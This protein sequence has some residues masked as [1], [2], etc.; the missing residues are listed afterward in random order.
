MVSNGRPI[1]FHI[2][3]H[4][5]AVRAPYW[6]IELL[7][8]LCI[9]LFT[10][11]CEERASTLHPWLFNTYGH[12]SILSINL[13]LAE[14]W[15]W[16]VSFTSLRESTW[17]DTAYDQRSFTRAHIQTVCI[18]IV[19]NKPQTRQQADTKMVANVAIFQ[20]LWGLSVLVTQCWLTLKSLNAHVVQPKPSDTWKYWDLSVYPYKRYL[21]IECILFFSYLC[22]ALGQINIWVIQLFLVRT[23]DPN[24]NNLA[25]PR[26]ELA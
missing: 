18:H 2:A 13:P 20:T 12:N 4:L 5:C 6:L 7:T 1:L 24:W 8:S 10:G 17:C 22:C 21:F 3:R 15:P 16:H 19:L 11:L 14:D 9:T 25:N 26:I 23:T